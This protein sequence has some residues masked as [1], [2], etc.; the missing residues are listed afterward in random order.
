MS[1]TLKSALRI[2]SLITLGIALGNGAVLRA[3]D[4][5]EAVPVEA[6]IPAPAKLSSKDVERAILQALSGRKWVVQEKT[7]GKIVAHY[8]RGKSSATVTIRYETTKVDISAVGQSRRGGVP[9]RWI[10]NLKKDIN[11]FLRRAVVGK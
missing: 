9:V 10:E 6:T 2:L 5:K 1:T 8:E 3:A 7:D 4:P 11:V